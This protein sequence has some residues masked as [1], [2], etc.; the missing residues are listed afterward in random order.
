[1]PVDKELPQNEI[2]NVIKRAKATAVIYSTKKKEVIK[3]IEDNL[4]TDQGYRT[5]VRQEDRAGVWQGYAGC[6]RGRSGYA[7]QSSGYR[8]NAGGTDQENDRC[9]R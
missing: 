7:A 1:M 5:E 8:K 2:E 6:D 4:R 9:W 3:K